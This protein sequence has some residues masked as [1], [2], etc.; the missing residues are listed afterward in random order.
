MFALWLYGFVATRLC[1][2]AALWLRGFVVTWLT[3]VTLR[4]YAY[5]DLCF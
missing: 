4:L 3:C 1:G 2:Y 5:V